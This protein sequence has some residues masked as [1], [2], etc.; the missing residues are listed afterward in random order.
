MEKDK[1]KNK[2]FINDIEKGS[3]WPRHIDSV[4]E[5]LISMSLSKGDHIRLEPFTENG[6]SNCKVDEFYY[7]NYIVDK[8]CKVVKKT[9][10]GECYTA[11][12][13]YLQS[14]D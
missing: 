14:I 4:C 6:E 10:N 3:N 11:I 9:W 2:I 1:L 13:I 5:G 7:S 12:E 8:M